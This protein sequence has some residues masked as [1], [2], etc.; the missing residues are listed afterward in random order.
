MDC[1]GEAFA[2]VIK[3]YK[4]VFSLDKKHKFSKEKWLFSFPLP[5]CFAS[6]L[7]H[8]INVVNLRI[9]DQ[10]LLVADGEDSVC[11]PQR[12]KVAQPIFISVVTDEV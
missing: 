2:F 7:P 6:H 11:L 12:G 3:A 1:Q 4:Y 5:S 9:F 10:H 8:H